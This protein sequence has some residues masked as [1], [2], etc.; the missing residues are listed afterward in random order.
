MPGHP[1]SERNFLEGPRARWR[2]F[3]TVGRVNREMIRGFRKLHFVGP[4]VTVFGSARVPEGGREYELA[5]RVGAAFAEIGF[6]IITGGGPGVMEAANRG[7]KEAGGA[8]IGC[9]IRLPHEQDPNPYLDIS[10]DFDYFFVRKLMLVKYSY[11]FIVMPGGFGT[12]DEMF[13]SLT[14][15][16]T[17]K[18]HDF[19]VVVMGS[20]HWEPL[21][22]QIDT[23]VETGM[24]DAKD[25]ELVL[26]TDDVDHAVRHVQERTVE[27]FGLRKKLTPVR[28]F[29]EHG[30]TERPHAEWRYEGPE[31][32]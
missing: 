26:F 32:D 16:Q 19:P 25:V 13:E 1:L 10:V 17:A 8:S 18:I 21:R 24:I 20:S 23:L 5:R 2:E 30:F 9:N 4:C 29:G 11:A 15:I 14:L 6:T 27:R 3:R 31:A 22:A 7:A 28:L 12:L